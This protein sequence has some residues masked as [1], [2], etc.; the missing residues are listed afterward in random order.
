[1]GE[2]KVGQRP[3]RLHGR[4]EADELVV[5]DALGEAMTSLVEGTWRAPLRTCLD[6]DGE[7]PI[8]PDFA[9]LIN[10]K[11]VALADAQDK[12]GSKRVPEDVCHMVVYGTAFG[13]RRGHLVYAE[14]DPEPAVHRVRCCGVRI[15]RHALDLSQ[16]QKDLLASIDRLAQESV[17]DIAGAPAALGA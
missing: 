14:G 10:G 6:V 13:V 8:K 7:I 12:F 11:P 15:V 9:F 4:N 5:L 3:P 16:G 17:A 1:V 2:P